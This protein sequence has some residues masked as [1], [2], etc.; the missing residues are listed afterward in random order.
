[1]HIAI[2]AFIVVDTTIV[3]AAVAGTVITANSVA[4]ASTAV[5][6]ASCCDTCGMSMVA[7]L[8]RSDLLRLDVMVMT[9]TVL[10]LSGLEY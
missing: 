7:D 8:F 9:S 4:T 5:V 1:M 10:F 6:V 2:T 3:T